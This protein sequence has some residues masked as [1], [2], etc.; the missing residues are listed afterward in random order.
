MLTLLSPAKKLDYQ[1]P[2]PPLP[3]TQPALLDY[4]EPL[5]QLCRTLTPAQLASLMKLSDK[6]ADLNAGRF[7]DWQLPFTR[8]NARQTLLAFKGDVYVGLRAETFSA[9]DFAFA[10]QT[11]RILSGLYGVLRPLDLIQP[12]R[13]EMGVRLAN[14]VGRDL[15]AYW[16]PVIARTLRATLDELGDNTVINLASDEY[17]RAVDVAQLD[18]RIVKPVFYDRHQG[19]YKI[20]SFYTKRARGMMA[21]YIIQQRLTAPEQLYDFDEAGYAFDD[22]ASDASTLV[23]RR[24]YPQ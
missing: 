24:D 8:E 16:K 7:Q 11:L 12:Y 14:P 15:Y 6:L 22:A 21:R 9:E 17:F 23:F 1:T 4:A 18:A 19:Q 3:A 20:I 10:Q 13:L 5:A 2:C